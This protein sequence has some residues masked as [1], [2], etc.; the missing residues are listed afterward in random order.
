MGFEQEPG[1]AGKQ[2]RLRSFDMMASV[3]MLRYDITMFG[4]VLPETRARVHDEEMSLMAEGVDRAMRTPFTF[5]RQDGELVYFVRGEKRPYMGMLLTGLETARQEAARDERKQFLYEMAVGDL[6]R[7]YQM[8]ALKPGERMAWTSPYPEDKEDRFGASFM[9]VECGF[10]PERKAGFIYQATCNENGSVTIESQMVDNSNAAA[11]AR[12]E[13]VA[14]YDPVANIDILRRSYD[15]EMVKQY[16]GRFYAGSRKAEEGENA[17][18]ELQR[19][20]DLVQYY[21]R[22]L[23]T[24][25]WS[26]EPRAVIEQRTRELTIGVW[27]TFKKRL[28]AVTA[29]QSV[30][31]PAKPVYEV[32]SGLSAIQSAIL[33]REVSEGYVEAWQNNEVKPG[34]GGGLAARG[35]N[36]L[37]DIDGFATFTS[38]FGENKEPRG[39]SKE[40]KYEFDTEMFCV[41][42]QAPPKKEEKKKMCGPCGICQGCDTKIRTKEKAKVAL[43]A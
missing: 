2:E 38:I 12:V 10:F 18:E 3:D 32:A 19:H 40:K 21:L 31:S 1:G 13:A 22:E 35:D 23:E 29:A 28:N 25:A 6:A 41:V 8:N 37:G 42:C 5:E 17:W 15:G 26:T 9:K 20:Q 4:H 34:C 24:I 11:F 27:K 33:R 7:G 36:P 14:Q 39:S 30:R 16:G 43:G